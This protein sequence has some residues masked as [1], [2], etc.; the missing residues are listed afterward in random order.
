MNYKVVIFDLDGT[1]VDSVQGIKYS[2][3]NVLRKLHLPCHDTEAYAQFLGEGLKRL[4]YKVLPKAFQTEEKAERCYQLML[5]EY[6][7]NWAVGMR[8]YDNIELLLDA[9]TER[10]LQLAINTNKND[11]MTQAIVKQYLSKWDFV[12]VIGYNQN[13]PRKPDPYGAIS[14]SQVC[15]VLPNECIYVGDTEVDIE[16][17]INAGMCGVAVSWGF[18]TEAQLNKNS[19]KIMISDPLELLEIID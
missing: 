18:R 15:D 5:E 16:T 14:I 1:L 11:E 7:E 9:L 19:P 4:A 3:N 13:N 10:K 17:A 6:A 2:M 12:S 8:V